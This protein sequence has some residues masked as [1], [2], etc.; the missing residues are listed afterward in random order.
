MPSKEKYHGLN[1][2][3]ED[4]RYV[5]CARCGFIAKP[6]RDQSAPDG[7]RIG[8]GI[9]NTS[10]DICFQTYDD[11]DFT[12]LEYYGGDTDILYDDDRFSYNSEITYDGA[13]A[14]DPSYDGIEKTI[15]DPVVTTGCPQCGTLRYNK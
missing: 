13:R 8:W 4:D 5:R 9:K 6:N 11:V 12:G 10:Y 14:S 2:S 15:Y 3:P 7:S 1:A